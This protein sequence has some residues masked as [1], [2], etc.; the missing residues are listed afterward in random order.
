MPV[1]TIAPFY[2]LPDSKSDKP[3]TLKADLIVLKGLHQ[4]ITSVTYPCKVTVTLNHFGDI[5]LLALLIM[6][7]SDRPTEGLGQ[8]PNTTW[9][10]YHNDAGVRWKE[11]D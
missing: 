4:C 9:G 3:K 6:N 1:F 2:K 7:I 5:L 11:G 10:D 8:W